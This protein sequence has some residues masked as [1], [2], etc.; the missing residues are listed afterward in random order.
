M[1]ISQHSVRHFALRY[2]AYSL[3]LCL[4][5]SLGS[6]RGEVVSTQR[7]VSFTRQTSFPVYA[8]GDNWLSQVPVLPSRHMPYSRTPV[9]LPALA[10]T[11]RKL[12]PALIGDWVGFDA[13]PLALILNGPRYSAFRGS[14]TRPVSSL[15]PA[16]HPPLLMMHA[17]SFLSCWLGFA[18]VGLG[19]NLTHWVT[20]TSFLLAPSPRHGL[21]WRDSERRWFWHFNWL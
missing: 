14:I 6:L 13:F 2:L 7:L 10:L 16:S 17:G 3:L 5:V 18:Q 15:H 11:R 4:P 21:A 19:S 8:Q 9:V 12:L 1:P 20:T